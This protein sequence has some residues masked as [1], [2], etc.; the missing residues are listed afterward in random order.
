MVRLNKVICEALEQKAFPGVCVLVSLHGDLIFKNAW[1]YKSL[2][3]EREKCLPEDIF[4][5]ASLTKP[6]VTTF[7]IMELVKDGRLSLD[8]AL[9]DLNLSESFEVKVPSDKE[10]ITIKQMLLHSAGFM[11]HYPFFKHFQVGTQ[12]DEVY[13][14]ILKMPLFYEPGS[15]I[16]YSDLGF[17]L[18]EMII[19]HVSKMDL[20]EYIKVIYGD[21]YLK[22][23]FLGNCKDPKIAKMI[24]PTE[25]CK[26]RGMLLRGI[27]HDE[28]AY[29]M[30][31]YSGHAG[32]F[33][34]ATDIFYI[35]HAICSLL[36]SNSL[37][38]IFWKRYKARD[39]RERALGWDIPS[40]EHTS[41]GRYFSDE[42]VGHLG[43]T[44]CSI[45][46]DLKRELLVVILTN[47][48]HPSRENEKIRE[49]RPK[50]HDA[51]SED[52]GI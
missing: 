39:G 4:D 45:W 35:T 3:P 15:T 17:I 7:L 29:I 23:T 8:T 50:I 44:G 34:T 31:G 13:K 20:K 48:V 49:Y 47:R 16:L 22:G 14:L 38:G 26:W 21:L 6:L 40:G 25:Y 51:I 33:T 43:Y 10:K 12:K 9:G 36:E 28:N 41:A 24:A 27:V 11:P 46:L 32:L 19:T 2:I 5:V 18:L 1:G 42:S 30:G 52:L 37:K